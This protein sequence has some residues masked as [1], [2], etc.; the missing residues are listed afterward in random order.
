M[1][2]KWQGILLECEEWFLLSNL[3]YDSEQAWYGKLV[4]LIIHPEWR[5]SRFGVFWYLSRACDDRLRQRM[6]VYMLKEKL[7]DYRNIFEVRFAENK[8]VFL[9][10][11]FLVIKLCHNKNSESLVFKITLINIVIKLIL[12]NP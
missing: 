9:K 6:N 12:Y 11:Q 10:S 3:F 5:L 4:T 7:R 1:W 8:N 2:K